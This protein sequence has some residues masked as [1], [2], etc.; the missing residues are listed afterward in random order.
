[1][2]VFV[3]CVAMKNR[4][5]GEWRESDQLSPLG[6]SVCEKTYAK[7]KTAIKEAEPTVVVFG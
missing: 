4:F 3:L 2:R 5:S 1:M 7:K 6:H